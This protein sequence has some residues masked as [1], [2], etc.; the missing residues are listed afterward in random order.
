[1]AA[2]RERWASPNGMNRVQRPPLAAREDARHP[3]RQAAARRSRRGPSSAGP[4]TPALTRAPRAARRCCSRPATSR[5]T[6]PRSAATPS[7]CCAQTASTSAASRGLG[8]CGMPA[9]EH[10]DLREL[11]RRAR[12]NLDVLDS[13]RR[14]RRQGA[15]P[16]TR[17]ARMMLRREYPTLVAAEDR[18]RAQKLA[19]AVRDPG[20]YLPGPGTCERARASPRLQRHTPSEV[21]YHAPC[22]LR[23]QAVGFTARDLLRRSPASADTSRSASAAGTTAPTR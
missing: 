11:R 15:W 7:R 6:S 10:G 19:A 18:D 22:H 3:P 17:P 4:R 8:C 12:R 2:R 1:M 21:A 9:W 14:G 5:T 13:P 16:S 20:E 23:A